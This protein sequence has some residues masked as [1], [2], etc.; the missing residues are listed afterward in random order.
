MSEVAENGTGALSAARFRQPWVIAAPSLARQS[1]PL[2]I[3]SQRRTARSAVTPRYAR[4]RSAEFAVP[5]AV[6][7]GTVTS[8][9]GC[10][11]LAYFAE[12]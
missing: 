9:S 12:M 2:R 4:T 10:S 11:R 8:G 6:G 1:A 7:G 3:Q 5:S